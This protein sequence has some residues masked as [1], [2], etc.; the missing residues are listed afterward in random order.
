MLRK[1]E[2]LTWKEAGELVSRE[3]VYCLLPIGAIEQHGLQLPIGCDD[4]L[5]TMAL[6]S[7][8]SMGAVNGTFLRLPAISYGCSSEHMDFPGTIALEPGVAVALIEQVLSSLRFHGF[9]RVVIVNS[10]G[11]NTELINAWEKEWRRRL[12][13]EV[14]HIH[15]YI[16]DFYRQAQKYMETSVDGDIHAGE[17]E[18]SMMMY[19]RPELVRTEE[20]LPERDTDIC[21]KDYDSGWASTA[22][23]PDNGVMGCPSRANAHKGKL[24]FEYTCDELVRRLNN[25]YEEGLHV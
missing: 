6:D 13:M 23:A 2:T 7:I 4:L 17:L 20:I 25:I 12:G 16:S 22:F 11:G 1:Y 24:L 8:E 9:K 15:F 3:D 18:T 14:Y 21:L 5:L 19:L 10:H